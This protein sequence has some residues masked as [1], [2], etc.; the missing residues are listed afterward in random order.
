MQKEREI[1]KRER[2]SERERERGSEREREREGERERERERDCQR[3]NVV[4]E[5][6]YS[7][8]NP[9]RWR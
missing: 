2:G 7:R 1:E 3:K 9:N 5:M 6:G 8:K 4:S